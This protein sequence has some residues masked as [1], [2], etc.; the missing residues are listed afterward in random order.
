LRRYDEALA[1]FDVLMAL[2]PGYAEGR[3]SRALPCANWAS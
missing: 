3:N 2:A 1:A